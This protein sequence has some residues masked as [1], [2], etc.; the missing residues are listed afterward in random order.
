[1][2]R[3]HG[4]DPFTAFESN[5]NPNYV[6][7]MNYLYEI[8]GVKTAAGVPRVDFSRQ[9]LGSLDENS[10]PA[11]LGTMP[12][13]IAWY[14]PNSAVDSS[15]GTTLAKSHCDG[16]PLSTAED[17]ARKLGIGMVR[18]DGTGVVTPPSVNGVSIDWNGDLN[19]TDDY[20]N[21]FQDITFNGVTNDGA[22]DAKTLLTGSDDWTSMGTS[23]LRQIGGRRGIAGLSVDASKFDGSKFDG[24]KFDGSKFDGSKFDGSKFDGSAEVGDDTLSAVGHPAHTLTAQW[25][26]RTVQAT[27]EAPN[28]S[29]SG[30]IAAYLLYRV[31][32]LA[33]TADNLKK[34]VLVA[35]T[36]STT[37]TDT[38]VTAG[39][40]YT[41]FV[42]VKFADRTQSGMS[43]Q[44]NPSQ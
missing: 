4:G 15:L 42:I 39:K 10:L 3:D 32:G 24:S 8:D 18:I 16:S 29:Q 41:Y 27:W 40:P 14:A 31:D 1:M 6:S 36:S 25:A 26:G 23:G 28:F 30:G 5:C 22:A 17:N 13:R 33:V 43:N 7:V 9:S 37:A 35:Q 44:A 20:P 11:G 2:W 38:K 21:L 12:Y 19:L 34:K